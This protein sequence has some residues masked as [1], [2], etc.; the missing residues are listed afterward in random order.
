MN[1]ISRYLMPG[2]HTRQAKA[3]SQE[4]FKYSTNNKS[5]INFSGRL[6]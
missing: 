1:L 2:G 6:G 5:T 3:C 4:C